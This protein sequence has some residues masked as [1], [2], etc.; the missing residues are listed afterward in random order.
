MPV[1][2]PAAEKTTG[3]SFEEELEEVAGVADA[4]T[5]METDIDAVIARELDLVAEPSPAE[6]RSA[7]DME[8]DVDDE[9]LSLVGDHQSSHARPHQPS[10]SNSHQAPRSS[11]NTAAVPHRSHHD[12][13]P[14]HA[15]GHASSSSAR[16]ASIKREAGMA[17]PPATSH[18]SLPSRSVSAAP[19]KTER[20][21]M[22][23]PSLPLGRDNDTSSERAATPRGEDRPV[24]A[25]KKSASKAKQQPK[26][27]AQPKARAKTSGTTKGKSKTVKDVAAFAVNRGKKGSPLSVP[28]QNAAK[29]SSAAAAAS[30][31]SRSTSVMPGGSLGPDVEGGNEEEE[32]KEQD[33]AEDKLY[34]VCK[35]RY[36][37]EKVMI[38]CDRCD[39]WYHTQCV[40][41]P[42]L[43]VDLVDQFIC[44]ICIE[45][46]PHLS[47]RTTWK[48]RCLYG[49]T[50]RNPAS[51][52]ACHKPAR[53]AFSKYCSDECG[54][55]CMQMRIGVWADKGGELEGLWESVKG[56][57]KREG[58]V[59]STQLAKEQ[60]ALS[61]SPE[62]AAGSN[63]ADRM[64]ADGKTSEDGR[65]IGDEPLLGIVKPKKAKAERELERLRPQL[66]DV[67]RKREATKKELEIVIWREK[68]TEL[69]VQRSEIVEECGWDQRLC[70]GDEEV[71]EFGAGVLESYEEGGSGTGRW[72]KL[73]I[74]E[75]QFD[76]EMKDSA[77]QKLTTR[78]REIRKR[79]EDIVDPQAHLSTTTSNPPPHPAP[80]KNS[81]TPPA[82][83]GHPKT[84]VN[85]DT[86]KKGKK[87]KSE[88]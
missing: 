79:I 37:D 47:L 72:Q 23:P 43:E 65:M 56:A 9:L 54:V 46:N 60:Q 86:T 81:N 39:E 28:P 1:D 29:K 6:H 4:P 82:H 8:A 49:L 59:V 52:E 20:E 48:R 27:P 24:P 31:R 12:S 53:G 19:V 38:A 67:V 7:D 35:T 57:E 69:A 64:K 44:P 36:D 70:F 50:Q 61:Q 32:D 21:S 42:D 18:P 5:A 71:A 3:L 51:S 76:K 10:H 63:D 25:K 88:A 62:V 30:G 83:H 55:K 15:K 58:V 87:R 78:E 45:N 73:R 33:D 80:L 66:D 13:H 11:L 17:F 22:P 34:C 75:I 68:L 14:K 16:D 26:Q 40:N 84:K 2:Q 74:A 85:G 41:M 77:L